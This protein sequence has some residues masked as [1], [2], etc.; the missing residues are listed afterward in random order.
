MRQAVCLFL[1]NTTFTPFHP[2]TTSTRRHRQNPYW[3]EPVSTEDQGTESIQEAV[4][5]SEKDNEEKMTL[6]STPEKVGS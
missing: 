4:S 2:D 6:L 5:T 1:W 3:N